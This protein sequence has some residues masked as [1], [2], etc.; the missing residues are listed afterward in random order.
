MHKRLFRKN[1]ISPNWPNSTW[2][3]RGVGAH[4]VVTCI[5]TVLVSFL[6]LLLFIL[7]L[8]CI[9]S[10]FVVNTGRR[11]RVSCRDRSVTDFL[12]VTAAGSITLSFALP[13]SEQII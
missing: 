6:F 1:W 10:T 9:H 12:F 5:A 11:V 8:Y 7:Q 3:L 2:T 4:C 13:Q